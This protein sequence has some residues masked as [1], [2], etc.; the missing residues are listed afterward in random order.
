M[1]RAVMG[2]MLLLLWPDGWDEALL[3]QDL[4]GQGNDVALQRWEHFWFCEHK[5]KTW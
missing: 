3:K 2:W 4:H 1:L 5:Q